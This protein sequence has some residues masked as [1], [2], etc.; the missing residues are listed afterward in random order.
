MNAKITSQGSSKSYEEKWWAVLWSLQ[1]PG[2]VKIC[3]WRAFHEILPTS[4]NLAKRG[5]DAS[6]GCPRCS[7]G[8]ES[9]YH[10]LVDC[11]AAKLV[12]KSRA[13]RDV[14][15][16]LTQHPFIDVLLEIFEKVQR[17]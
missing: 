10:A 6:R 4:L 1:I 16:Q 15:L 2:K 17:A 7:Y 8:V 3:I 5:I 12:R 9:S 13:Y 14:F 11:Q